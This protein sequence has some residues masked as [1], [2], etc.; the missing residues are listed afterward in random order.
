MLLV[1]SPAKTLDYETPLPTSV[2]T[3][4]DYLDD[5]AQLVKRARKYSVDDVMSLMAVSEKIAQL[6]V[7]RFKKW[8]RPFTPKHARQAVLAFKG[9][10]YVGLD[11]FTMSEDDLAFAQQHLRILS[12]LYGLLR[13][14]DLMLPYRLEMGRKIDTERGKNLYEFWGNSVTES[15]NDQFQERGKKHL[16]NLASNE[17]FKVIKPKLLQ[18][19]IITPHFKE[20]KNGTYKVLGVY[21][22]KARGMLSRYIIKNRIVEPEAIKHF[23]EDGYRFNAAMSSERDWVFARRK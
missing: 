15:L 12:G 1:I 8:R 14:L 9:D 18:A 11:A 7:E 20:Y 17:Y 6:N 19:E 2:H 13:P 23:C 3:M 22:K 10:V 21:A 16:I 4:P 5:A